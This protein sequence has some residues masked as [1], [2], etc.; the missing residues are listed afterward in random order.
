MDPDFTFSAADMKSDPEPKA[1]TVNIVEMDAD[2]PVAPDQSRADAW[3]NSNKN[4]RVPMIALQEDIYKIPGQNFICFSVIKPEDY[5]ALHHKDGSYKGSLIKFR[6]VFESR[7]EADKHIRK[8]MKSDRHFDV[9]LVPAFT[10][11]GMDDD[12]I[13]DREYADSA[14]SDII[15]G[16][17]QTE[18]NRMKGVRQRIKNTQD[19]TDNDN[20]R[21]EESTQFF[22]KALEYKKPELPAKPKAVKAQTLAELASQLDITPGGETVLTQTMDDISEERLESVV[23]EIL[24]EDEEEE[25]E[26]DEEN[27]PEDEVDGLMRKD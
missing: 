15:K 22:N 23:S 21:D 8:V 26:Q 1:P 16:Y 14:I 11:A 6:G 7:E 17:F 3:F 25:E 13:E 10:W 9:H 2:T 4:T 12:I 24:L 19:G 5:G 20:M 27:D 18:N